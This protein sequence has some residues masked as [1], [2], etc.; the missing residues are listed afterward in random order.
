MNLMPKGFFP[1][2]IDEDLSE[3]CAQPRSR[4]TEWM[5]DK[6]SNCLL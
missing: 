1:T 2:Q 4:S 6:L 3:H 5:E